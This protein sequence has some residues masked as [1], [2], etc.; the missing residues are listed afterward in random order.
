MAKTFREQVT[1]F[2][3]RIADFKSAEPGRV[4]FQNEFF[5]T[6][7]QARSVKVWNGS[8]WVEKALKVW[9]GSSWVETPVKMWNGSSWVTL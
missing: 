8:S 7:S 6:Q 9:N 3:I 4:L 5:D 1:S 2:R